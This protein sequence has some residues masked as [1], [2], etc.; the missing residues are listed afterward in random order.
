MASES[1]WAKKT[2]G[3]KQLAYFGW[4]QVH[5]LGDA[6][7]KAKVLAEIKQAGLSPEELEELK[8]KNRDMRIPLMPL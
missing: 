2:P 6:A 8:K 1:S 3:E 4:C 5:M 7:T